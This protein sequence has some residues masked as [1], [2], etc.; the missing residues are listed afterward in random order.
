MPLLGFLLV[1]SAVL[2]APV[3][4]AL[5]VGRQR[6]NRAV[7]CTLLAACF[8]VSSAYMLWRLER[9][10]VW[11]HGTPGASLLVIYAGYAVAYG[12]IGWFI[13][14]AILSGRR[15]GLRGQI[16]RQ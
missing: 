2:S 6:I 3:M 1:W 4:V 14:R 12:A 9:F 15:S 5:L 16:A 8:A 7:G 10:D 11:R 13:A